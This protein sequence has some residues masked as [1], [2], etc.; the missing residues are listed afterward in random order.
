[1]IVFSLMMQI[2][3]DTVLI[4]HCLSMLIDHCV[5]AA[6]CGGSLVAVL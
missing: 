4:D 1:M 3:H 6:M 2:V 5:I